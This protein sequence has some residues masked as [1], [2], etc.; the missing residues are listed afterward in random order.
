MGL[1]TAAGTS[2]FEEALFDFAGFT[3]RHCEGDAST[4]CLR[5]QNFLSK[6]VLF[7]RD[8]AKIGYLNLNFCIPLTLSTA[9]IRGALP[10]FRE[11]GPPL[12]SFYL[13][14]IFGP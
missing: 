10:R 2:H 14:F 1:E 9:G 11:G 4:I 8:T 6:I 13:W 3:L 5:Y 7:L 12:I